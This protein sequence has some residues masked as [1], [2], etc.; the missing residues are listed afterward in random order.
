[1]SGGSDT[2]TVQNFP[3]WAIPY[4]QDYQQF[5]RQVAGQE[6]NPYTG[7]TVAQMNPYQTAGYDAMAQRA[8]QGSGVN[9]A[10]SQN[11]QDTLNGTYLNQGNPYLSRQI[12]MASQDVLRNMDVL[13][14]R[15]GSFG[16][17]GVQEATARGISD[18]ATQMRGADYAAERNRQMGAIGMAPQIANQDYFDIQQLTNAGQAYQGQEQANLTDQYNRFL[19][20]RDYPNQQL[21]TMARGLGMGW[22]SSQTGPGNNNLAQGLGTAMALYGAYNGYGG[23]Q[24]GSK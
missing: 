4:A 23:S 21:Q 22:G 10:A 8:M 12:D 5:A 15:S 6:Y 17:S 9:D 20:A 1:M 11:L 7:Q 18:I 19:E 14:A 16:N 2:T 3:D 24:G 13:N